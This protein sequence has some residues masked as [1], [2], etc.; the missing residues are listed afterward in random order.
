MVR[1]QGSEILEFQGTKTLGDTGS[2]ESHLV[3]FTLGRLTL[4]RLLVEFDSAILAAPGNRQQISSLLKNY[5]YQGEITI[6][7]Y[8]EITGEIINQISLPTVSPS[9]EPFT[10]QPITIIDGLA[11]DTGTKTAANDLNIGLDETISP[12]LIND[13]TAITTGGDDSMSLDLGD[14]S[15]PAAVIITDIDY[16]VT[17]A[18]INDDATDQATKGSILEN[19]WQNGAPPSTGNSWSDPSGWIDDGEPLGV[20]SLLKERFELIE[21]LGAGG[22]GVVYKAL[23]RRKVEAQDRHPY[24]ALKILNDKFKKHPKALQALQREAKKT[25]EL[26]HPNIMTVYD[27][28][29]VG[30]NVFM[31]M[32]FLDGAPLDVIIGRRKGKPF[33]EDEAM[34][35]IEGMS[36]ALGYAHRRNLVHSD[37]KPGNVFLTKEGTIKVLD[38]GIAA[39][40]NNPVAGDEEESVETT[41]FDVKQL[42]AFT[43]AYASCAILE[44]SIPD[45]RDDIYALGCVAYQ[46]LSGKHPFKRKRA[47]LA[48]DNGMVVKPIP[49]LNR[50]QQNTLNQSLAFSH[51]QCMPTIEQFIDGMRR[52]KSKLLPFSIG[53]ALVLLVIT[54]ALKTIIIDYLQQQEHGQIMTLL[55]NKDDDKFLDGLR[56]LLSAEEPLRSSLIADARET[57]LAYYEKQTQLLIDNPHGPYNF[58]KASFLVNDART[59][60][61]DS[62]QIQRMLDTLNNRSTLLLNQLTSRFNAALASGN[63]LSNPDTDDIIE[64]LDRVK[65]INPTHPLIDDPRLPPAYVAR[66]KTAL[67]A[68]DYLLASAFV[69]KGLDYFPENVS[70]INIRDEINAVRQQVKTSDAVATWVAQIKA[71]PSPVTIEDFYLIREPLLAISEIEP[72]NHFLSKYK[73]TL[74]AFIPA[75]NNQF[76]EQKQWS[77]GYDLLSEFA[78]LLTSEQVIG[79]QQTIVAAN[80]LYDRTILDLLTQFEN[81][82]A[83]SELSLTTLAL[84][85]QLL[86]QLNSYA[87]ADDPNLLYARN[88]ISYA[89]LTLARQARAD[90]RLADA[91]NLAQLAA[92]AN[93]GQIIAEAIRDELIVVNMPDG[94]AGQR[95]ADQ[96]AEQFDALFAQRKPRQEAATLITLLDQLALTDPVNAHIARGRSSVAQ[97]LSSHVTTMIAD[98]DWNRALTHAQAARLLLPEQPATR[99]LPASVEK[100][101]PSTELARKQQ[102]IST[103]TEKLAILLTEPAFTPP[104][105]A[106][107]AGNWRRLRPLLA[108]RPKQLKMEEDKITQAILTGVNQSQSKHLFVEA[109]RRLRSGKRILPDNP[110]FRKAQ[111]TLAQDEDNFQKLEKF[112]TQT[113]EIDGLKQT[114]LTQIDARS[115]IEAEVTLEKLRQLLPDDSQFLTAEITNAL[116]SAYLDQAK[117]LAEQGDFSK[118]LVLTGAGLKVV[119]NQLGLRNSHDLYKGEAALSKL[120]AQLADVLRPPNQTSDTFKA[121]IETIRERSPVRAGALVTQFSDLFAKRAET[122]AGVGD[123]ARRAWLLQGADLFPDDPRFNA[124]NTSLKERPC[125]AKVVGQGLLKTG[126]CYDAIGKHARGPLMVVIPAT[127]PYAIGKYEISHQEFKLFCGDSRRCPPQGDDML[128][129]VTQVSVGLAVEYTQ[130]LSQQT[131]K[132]Y[133]LPIDEEW[134]YAANGDG[135][136]SQERNCQLKLGGTIVKDTRLMPVDSGKANGWGLHNPAGNVQELTASNTVRGGA[137]SDTMENC[138]ISLKRNY[139]GVADKFTGFRVVQEIK[140]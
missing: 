29:R 100:A 18:G 127:P 82:F 16:G 110:D 81:S 24:V 109:A 86:A 54:V 90:N 108:D 99:A 57:I 126:V 9:A 63:L 8:K 112:Q 59:L 26:A 61:P 96:I 118:A 88:R 129:P 1:Q 10:K 83:N 120:A 15:D 2:L 137:Y 55:V 115:V 67:N 79:Q 136:I 73:K 12:S 70:L 116:G 45:P 48:R 102:L 6:S 123:A 39:R 50:R 31:T 49:T 35:M 62:A 51:A 135:I 71:A 78:D 131:G 125:T 105:E 46:L 36:E 40:I 76:I 69:M 43:P 5:L 19:S 17:L 52:K 65:Q 134:I 138:D 97:R 68:S 42:G 139:S 92:K 37:F 89:Y 25:Q 80:S 94:T 41:V 103:I 14:F 87:L 11:E 66:A 132:T 33:P 106:D 130:W 117:A 121:S 7:A 128:L 23:D 74:Q 13:G 124:V 122:T 21:R 32:E 104:W 72:Q 114:L 53:L 77:A 38:F 133:R 75:A 95:Q 91:R 34:M 107:M 60:Y 3:A 56:K 140:E 111:K 101:K 44:G 22:M 28:D 47:S 30:S 20:G 64:I 4:H 58:P 85:N 113:G 27:F 119:P 84:A 98:D 93:P